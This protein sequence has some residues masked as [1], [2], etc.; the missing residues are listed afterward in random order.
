MR[1]LIDI[2]DS[3][4]IPLKILAAKESVCLKKY[5]ENLLSNQIIKKNGKLQ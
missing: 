1:K 5:I 2:K 3:E 4:I